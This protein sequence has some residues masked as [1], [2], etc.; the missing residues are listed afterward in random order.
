MIHLTSITNTRA[1][2]KLD[3]P[4]NKEAKHLIYKHVLTF[5][6]HS[7]CISLL[8]QLLAI[9]AIFSMIILDA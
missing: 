9:K 5:S 1:L 2:M 8:G 7:I 4:N 6:K 3:Q